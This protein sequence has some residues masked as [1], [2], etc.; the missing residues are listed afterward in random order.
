[1]PAE[2]FTGCLNK[3]SF[4]EL[5]ISRFVTNIISI[6]F[7][8]EARSPKAQFGKT[9]FFLRHLLYSFFLF[10]SNEKKINPGGQHSRVYIGVQLL[11]QR[12]GCGQR[13]QH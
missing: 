2:V 10:C 12:E 9:H 13:P 3:L 8:L 7:Q 4:T 5:S 11:D 1:M 6:S